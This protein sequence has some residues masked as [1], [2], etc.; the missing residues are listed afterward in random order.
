[1]F[2]QFELA[3]AGRLPQVAT[4]VGV[5]AVFAALIWA[6]GFAQVPVLHDTFHEFRH[7]VGLPCH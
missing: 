3:A 4:Y 5:A 6:V 1:M 7:A 2:S